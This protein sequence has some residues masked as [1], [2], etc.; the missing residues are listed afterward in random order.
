MNIIWIRRLMRR[1]R[2]RRWSHVVEQ[3]LGQSLA[4]TAVYLALI[5]AAHTV[6]MMTLEGMAPGDALWLTLTTATTVGYGDISAATALGRTATVVLLYAGG[7]FVV[8]KIAGDYF[9]YRNERRMRMARG[10]WEWDM[11]NHIVIINIPDEDPEHY[12]RVLIGQFRA[13]KVYQDAPIQ[14]LTPDFADGFPARMSELAEVVHYHAHGTE[15][16]ALRAVNVERAR[17]VVVLSRSDYDHSCDSVTFDILHRLRSAGVA[18]PVLAECVRDTNRARLRRA[19]ADIVIRPN[20]AYPGMVVRGFVAPGSEQL[21]EELFTSEGGE[22]RRLA[23]DIDCKPWAQVVIALI[24]NDFGVAVAYEDRTGNVHA[25]PAA[26]HAVNAQA[27][28]VMVDTQAQTDE[29]AVNEVLANL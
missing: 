1:R 24:E 8:A 11:D 16:E 27:L 10:E 22:Y 20:R 26:A 3:R 14:I 15:D 7:I 21:M 6:A 23:V 4:R 25:S 5:F 28:F 12:L 17:A 2:R 9:D 18:A 19:G 13:A 29:E